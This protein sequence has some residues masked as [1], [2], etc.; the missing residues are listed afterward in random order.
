MKS[1]CPRVCLAA[2]TVDKL[3]HKA[4]FVLSHR[5]HCLICRQSIRVIIGADL[6]AIVIE[7]W[8]PERYGEWDGVVSLSKSYS[9]ALGYLKGVCISGS[10]TRRQAVVFTNRPRY[11][12]CMDMDKEL[13]PVLCTGTVLYMT[14]QIPTRR[15][16]RSVECPSLSNC[17]VFEPK[18]SDPIKEQYT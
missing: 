2:G 16:L 9:R 17:L 10:M 3:L 5:W 14:D 13:D 11:V 4:L 15:V 18:Q 1:R 7:E 6:D 12:C 8:S